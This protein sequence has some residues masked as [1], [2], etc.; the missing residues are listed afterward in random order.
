MM[1]GGTF[2]A[3]RDHSVS[4]ESGVR[5]MREPA[6]V[7]MV[8]L[9]Y[10]SATVE[11][12]AATLMLRSGRVATAVSIN[13]ALGLFGPLLFVVVS[14]VGIW[15]LAQA[16]DVAWARLALI[17]AGVLLIVYAATR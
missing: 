2:R 5:C 9:R 15:G 16:N 11:L 7:G 6:L 10:L 4:R 1:T 3:G 12:V 8:A 13:A 14:A 17:A